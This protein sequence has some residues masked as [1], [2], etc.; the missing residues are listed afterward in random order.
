MKFAVVFIFMLFLSFA[1]LA[2]KYN[3]LPTDIKEDT[4]ANFVTAKG[5]QGTSP[6]TVKQTLKTLKAKCSHGKLVDR[7]RRQIRFFRLQ[8]CWG[9]PLADAAE[10]LKRQREEINRLKK[11]YTV[12]EMACQ[13]SELLQITKLSFNLRLVNALVKSAINTV[14]SL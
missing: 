3:C 4:V 12:L 14:L 1:V 8:G 6:I 9:N 2:Q 10:I 13:S 11:K 5:G 7:R